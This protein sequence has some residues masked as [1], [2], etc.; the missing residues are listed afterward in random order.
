[1]N[2][3][4]IVEMLCDWKAATMRH[5]DGNLSKSIEINQERYGYSDEL[6]SIFIKTARELDGSRVFHKARQS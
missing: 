1:M 4:D 2:L 5:N 3:L 6:K